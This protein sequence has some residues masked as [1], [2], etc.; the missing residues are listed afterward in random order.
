MLENRKK[1]S[2]SEYKYI[3]LPE[4]FNQIQS[5]DTIDVFTISDTTF[6]RFIPRGFECN[7][8]TIVKI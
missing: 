3:D 5:G 2:K 8:K 4:E 6:I 1:S 7:N